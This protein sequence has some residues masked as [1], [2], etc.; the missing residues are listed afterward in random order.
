MRDPYHQGHL[1]LSFEHVV[2][3]LRHLPPYI[4]TFIIHHLN[5]HVLLSTITKLVLQTCGRVDSVETGGAFRIGDS[6]GME[7]PSIRGPDDIDLAYDWLTG[8]RVDRYHL[9]RV[10]PFGG[11]LHE[12]DDRGGAAQEYTFLVR[13]EIFDGEEGRG[14]EIAGRG[15]RAEGLGYVEDVVVT[16]REEC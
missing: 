15:W 11:F 5:E 8:P 12:V 9:P 2:M 6:V 13:C 14:E 3:P 4:D 10:H 16:I 7:R 1:S